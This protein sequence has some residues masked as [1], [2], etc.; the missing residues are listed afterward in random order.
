MLQY[1]PSI[2]NYIKLYDM[3]IKE[4]LQAE[5]LMKYRNTQ[6]HKLDLKRR[7]S[8]IIFNSIC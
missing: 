4:I 3:T 1:L 2:S 5:V 8:I 6:K 7:F